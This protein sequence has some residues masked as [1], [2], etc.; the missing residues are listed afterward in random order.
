[1]LHKKIRIPKESAMDVME[2]LGKSDDAIQFVDL[3]LQD[4]EERKNFGILISRCEECEKRILNFEKI[5]TLYGEQMVKYNS[6]QTFKIDLENDKEQ[7]DQRLESNYFDLIENELIENE[8]RINELM[9]SYKDITEELDLLIEKKSVFDKS[10]QLMAVQQ[11]NLN[12]PRNSYNNNLIENSL[13]NFINTNNNKKNTPLIPEDDFDLTEIHIISG[14]INPEDDMRL[15]RMIFRASRGRAIPSFFDLTIK[16]ET[17][18]IKQE[19]KIFTIFFQGGTDNFLLNKIY[20]ICEMFKVNRFV[21]PKREEIAKA[22]IDIQQ[23]IYDKKTFLKT[24]ETS[25]RDFIKDKIGFDGIPAKY[26]LYRLYFLQEKMIFTNLNK[27]KLHG[28][29]IDGECWIPQEKFDEIQNNLLKITEKD[30]TK[31]TAVFTDFENDDSNP[32][33]YLKLNQFT[34]TFQLIVSEYGIPRY[35]EINPGFFTIISFP[36]MFGIMFGDIGHGLLLSIVGCLMV[37]KYDEIITNY[38]SFKYYLKSRYFFLFLGIFAFYNG[39]IYDDFFSIPLG[40]F[41]TCYRNERNNNGKLIAVREKDCVYPIGIDPKWYV[42]SNELT[43]INSFKMKMSVI[44]GVLQMILG[45]ILK[46]FN[47]Y[48]FNDPIDFFFE[49]IPQLVFMCLFFGYMCLMIYIKWGIDWSDDYSKAPSVITTLL[50]MFLNGG[51]VGEQGQKLPLWGRDDYTKQE[52]F[53]FYC[54]IICVICVPLMLIPKPIFEYMKMSSEE[55]NNEENNLA[56]KPRVTITDIIV[57]QIIETIEFVLGTVSHTASYLRLW[58]LSLAHAQLSKVFFDM[59]LLGF[60]QS[61]SIIGM[62]IGFFLLANITL[63]VLMGMDLLECTLHT[64]RLHWVEFQSK[65]Y[66]ADGYA[67]QPFSFKYINEDFL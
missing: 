19:K 23:E 17:L 7:I 46:G 49:F 5:V 62:M 63:G 35:Q 67:F 21:I 50:N 40:I 34:E 24:A 14:V 55:P 26:D 58:A 43:F 65:F 52:T 66:H 13:E 22:I 41:G 61:G 31:L 38:P 59:C 56:Q 30:P 39:W 53:Q 27:C 15:K 1:M 10:S 54:L 25:I 42:A 36:F 29:F 12:S 37:L 51:S 32:P 20:K 11:I 2:E 33:T 60:I 57:N 44:I 3:N 9:K 6:Y 8:K 28:N 4:F 18:N 45:L 16:N 48:F 47:A 64:L